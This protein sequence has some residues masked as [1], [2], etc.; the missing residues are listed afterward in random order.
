MFDNY[1]RLHLAR[2]ELLKLHCVGQFNFPEF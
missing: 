1:V 2:C